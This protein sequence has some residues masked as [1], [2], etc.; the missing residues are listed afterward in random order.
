MAADA[1]RSPHRNDVHSAGAGHHFCRA[2]FHLHR[3][4]HADRSRRPRCGRCADRRHSQRV[5]PQD[6][7]Q[8]YRGYPG[9]HPPVPG[10]GLCFGRLRAAAARP[11]VRSVRHPGLAGF[12]LLPGVV[13]GHLFH[14][15]PGPAAASHL[16]ELEPGPF[17]GPGNVVR[18]HHL[19]RSNLVDD[20]AHRHGGVHPQL[21][22]CAP[23]HL[24][25]HLG[26]DHR[27]ESQR[28]PVC[29]HPG[30]LLPAAGHLHG[31]LCHA[32]DHHPDSHAFAGSGWR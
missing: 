18:R 4:G 11:P 5:V 21:R 3:L 6:Q 2:R 24:P 14:R 32:G 13:S 12:H 17:C 19:H 29:H 9:R 8:P 10:G 22:L 26:V 25:G 7:R 15:E 31:K 30:V 27:P 16:P 23:R 20:H 28:P 1:L